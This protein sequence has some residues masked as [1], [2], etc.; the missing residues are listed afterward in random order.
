MTLFLL[1]LLFLLSLAW[2]HHTGWTDPA[3]WP[4]SEDSEPHRG[5]PLMR[6]AGAAW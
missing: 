3:N 2:L 4:R 6:V 1:A 5:H